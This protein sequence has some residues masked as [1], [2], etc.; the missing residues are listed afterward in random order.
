MKQL[1]IPETEKVVFISSGY[2]NTVVVTKM[3]R[4]Q[5]KKK[6]KK[7]KKSMSTNSRSSREPKPSQVDKKIQGLLKKLKLSND[8]GV[9]FMNANV[10]YKAL[11]HFDKDDLKVYL[12][13]SVIYKCVVYA[14]HK[15]GQTGTWHS[16]WSKVGYMEISEN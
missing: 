16:P 6:K 8:I 5:D 14:N 3:K 13:H 4:A 11:R 1:E 10:S 7:P 12:T 2:R 15:F 9:I